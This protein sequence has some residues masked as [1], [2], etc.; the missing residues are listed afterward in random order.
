MMVVACYCHLV[1]FAFWICQKLLD[2]FSSMSRSSSYPFILAFKV[3]RSFNVALT[4]S[5][6]A[7]F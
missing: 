2:I 7:F 3:S 1:K 6:I 5:A 4:E